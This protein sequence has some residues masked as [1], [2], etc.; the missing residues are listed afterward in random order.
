MQS[1]SMVIKVSY[2]IYKCF[3]CIL[4]RHATLQFI[5][6]SFSIL[7]CHVFS[8]EVRLKTKKRILS[9]SLYVGS[10]SDIYFMSEINESLL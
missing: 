5:L 6:L 1:H 10:K 7:L 4:R 2:Y 9:Y 8:M 3:K